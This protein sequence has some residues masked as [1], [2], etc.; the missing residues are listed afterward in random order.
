MKS[1]TN[2]L[3]DY[4]STEL[5]VYLLILSPAD[6]AIQAVKGPRRH[7]QDVGRV[8]LDSLPPQLPGVL[9]WHVHHGSL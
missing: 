3:L 9:L 4:S 2:V 1:P 6:D 5:L 7:K 8:H